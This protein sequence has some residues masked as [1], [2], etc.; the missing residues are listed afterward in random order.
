M[1]KNHNAIAPIVGAHRMVARGWNGPYPVVIDAI[2]GEWLTVTP[3]APDGHYVSATARLVR[4]SD[5]IRINQDCGGCV[6]HP[7]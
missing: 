1:Y 7:V 4:D 5:L 2:N 3:T 6:H